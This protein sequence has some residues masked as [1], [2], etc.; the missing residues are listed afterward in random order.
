[1]KNTK[2][3][4]EELERYVKMIQSPRVGRFGEYEKELISQMIKKGKSWCQ[5]RLELWN[6]LGISRSSRVIKHSTNLYGLG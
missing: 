1:M 2:S 4:G 5:I 3:R 6:Q